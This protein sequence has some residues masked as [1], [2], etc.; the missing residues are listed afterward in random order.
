VETMDRTPAE[1]FPPGEFIKEEIEARGWSQV[2]L[3]EILGRP[4]RLISELIAGKR[5]ITPET[6]R[7]LGD[8]FGTG[9]QFW[10]N[11]ESSY[12]LA[13]VKSDSSNAVSRRAK[14]YAKAPV[15]EMMRRHWIEPTENID[16]LQKRVLD[17]FHIESLEQEPQLLPHAARKSTSYASHTPAEQAWLSRA[18]QLAQAINVKTFSEMAF[19]AALSRLKTLLRD[20]EGTRQVPPILAEAGVRFLTIETLPQTRIDGAC[21]WLN[22][23]SP[24]IAMSLRFDR[25]DAFWHTLLHE[26]A[27]LKYRHG[28]EDGLMLDVNLVGEDTENRDEQSVAETQADEFAAN[29]SI[30]KSEL[31][32][33][34]MR[35]RPLFSKAKIQGLAARLDV[36]PGIVVG[37]LQHRRA[38]PYSHN[39]E[40]LTKVRHIVIEA[41]LT[42]GFGNILSLA[43]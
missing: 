42:D 11:L 33:F 24:V 7:G 9:A 15:K 28:I 25:I 12:R 22:E 4:P 40:M 43:G 36:H 37:Q 18:M 10:M 41:A 21:L 20:P 38:I 13:Q 39:R 3:A 30:Q 2:E 23:N 34:I 8:A 29:F 19:A 16:V 1:V 6:A 14:L 26:C 17:F 31:D 27:H 32:N 5:A 35:V